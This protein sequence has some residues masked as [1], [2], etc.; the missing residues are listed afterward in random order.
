[1]TAPLIVHDVAGLRKD[2]Q[3]VV[4]MLHDFTFRTPDEVLALHLGTRSSVSPHATSF[5]IHRQQGL[6]RSK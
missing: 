2:R 4:L 5:G 3:E 6:K 1:M